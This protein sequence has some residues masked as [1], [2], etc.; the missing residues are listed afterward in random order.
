MNA[1]LPAG[2]CAATVNLIR[3]VLLDCGAKDSA[4]PLCW[5]L[6]LAAGV[7]GLARI[8]EGWLL[9]DASVVECAVSRTVP[10][11]GGAPR[12]ARHFS[13]SPLRLNA[14]LPGEAKLALLAGDP[15]VRLRAEVPLD[16]DD[17]MRARIGGACAAF[18]SAADLMRRASGEDAGAAREG[19]A[20][21]MAADQ[22][23]EL[24]SLCEEADWPFTE[25]PDGSIAIALDVPGEFR[26]AHVRY[27]A[28]AC[29]ESSPRQ[30]RLWV[31]LAGEEGIA[32]DECRR[33]VAL[34]LLH[35]G[36]AVRMAR[37]AAN[38]S[39]ATWFEVICPATAFELQHALAALRRLSPLRRRGRCAQPRRV[40][41]P[42]LSSQ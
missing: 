9:L 5:R 11:E 37:P 34:L 6:P 17:N 8:D 4:G 41:R 39:G 3:D 12:T 28:V 21:A 35:A 15:A 29:E 33:A 16:P 1:L 42:R 10:D 20:E 7:T 18:A 24:R 30:V 23:S 22:A 40:D 38:E 32:S 26:Q 36:A 25:R 2:Y 19:A 14:S 13:W 27:A 31:P